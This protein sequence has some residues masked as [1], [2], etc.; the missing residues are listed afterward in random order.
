MGMML[1]LQR[2]P[3]VRLITCIHIVGYSVLNTSTEVIFHGVQH[4]PANKWGHFQGGRCLHFPGFSPPHTSR[5]YFSPS[6]WGIW[7]TKSF[8][9]FKELPNLKAGKRLVRYQVQFPHLQTVKSWPVSDSPTVTNRT[10]VLRS[11]VSFFIVF[12]LQNHF[13]L[14]F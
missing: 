6:S 4:S 3:S 11:S 5:P 7:T 13:S 9:I 8:T 14:C 2:W 1:R 10:Q 12:F